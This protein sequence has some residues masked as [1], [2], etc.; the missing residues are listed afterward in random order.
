VLAIVVIVG[1]IIWSIIKIRKNNS[2]KFKKVTIMTFASILIA[3]VSWVLNMGWVRFFM[4]ILLIPVVHGIVFLLA[5]LFFAKYIEQSPKMAKLNILF[6]ATYLIAY[7][8]LP[9]GADVGGMYFFFGLIHN[10]TLS[11]IAGSLS[12][13]AVIGHIALF[14][15]QMIEVFTIKKKQKSKQAVRRMPEWNE[16]VEMLYDKNLDF[17]DSTV[18]KVIYSKDKAKRYVV[19]KSEKGFYTYCLEKIHQLDEEEWNHSGSCDFVP[20]F[21]Q[22][23]DDRS[24]SVFST[25]EEA[26]KELEQEPEYKVFWS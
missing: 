22:D 14:V 4:T 15:I 20:A 11:T 17:I 24:L 8:F 9:D 7:L 2:S 6:I 1:G 23:A 3:A 26:L 10:D 25:L 5:N 21:W 13:I 18:E 16:I 19:L 12:G